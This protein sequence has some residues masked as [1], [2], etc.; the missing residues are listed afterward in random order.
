M[1][2]EKEPFTN[3][4]EAEEKRDPHVV[5]EPLICLLYYE[6]DDELDAKKPPMETIIARPHDL[7]ICA[8]TINATG[9]NFVCSYE[10]TC[11]ENI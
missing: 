1:V 4:G 9:S 10:I 2:E 11:G 8:T 3:C 6:F 5:A 7:P